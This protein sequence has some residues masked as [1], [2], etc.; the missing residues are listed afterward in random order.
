VFVDVLNVLEGWIVD[1]NGKQFTSKI[2]KH[3]LRKNNV[4]DKP[5][6]NSYPQLHG[7]VEAY[8]TR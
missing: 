6:L 7:K 2:F 4:R 5:I 1:D 3:F 8:I